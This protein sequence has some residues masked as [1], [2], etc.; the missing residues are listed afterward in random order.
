[1][2]NKPR[3]ALLA[4]AASLLLSSVVFTAP[5]DPPVSVVIIRSEFCGYCQKLEPTMM[6]LM[7]EYEA[8][9]NFVVLDVS[10]DE[11]A[12][13]AEQT[14]KKLGLAKFFAENQENTST[15]AIFA[16]DK[17]L[18]KSFMAE[19]NEA[20]YRQAFDSAIRRHARK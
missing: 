8:R 15:V 20:P 5:A 16:P 14:A 7:K 11:T 4:I 2:S 3:F 17:K 19:L 9:L 10:N 1:M 6:K 13:K 12:A 18:I